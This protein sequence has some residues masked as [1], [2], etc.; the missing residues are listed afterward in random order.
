MNLYSGISNVDEM[1]FWHFYRNACTNKNFAK[2]EVSFNS[3]FQELS[4]QDS[5]KP[6]RGHYFMDKRLY[7]LILQQLD[8]RDTINI[9]LQSMFY[10]EQVLNCY[11]VDSTPGLLL[12]KMLSNIVM[13]TEDVSKCDVL[14]EKIHSNAQHALRDLKKN[15]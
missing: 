12:S 9:A 4:A 14:C 10:E 5:Q 15:Y 2:Y 11:E 13:V 7:D 6:D 3:V 8:Y 1:L